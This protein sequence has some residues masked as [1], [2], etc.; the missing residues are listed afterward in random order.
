MLTWSNARQSSLSKSHNDRGAFRSA[1]GTPDQAYERMKEF[2]ENER[3]EELE[4]SREIVT[5]ITLAEK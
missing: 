5:D 2:L 1:M 3:M 4:E